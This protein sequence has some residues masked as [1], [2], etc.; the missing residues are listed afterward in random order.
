MVMLLMMIIMIIIRCLYSVRLSE[1]LPVHYISI[2]NYNMRH[3]KSLNLPISVLEQDT[4]HTPTPHLS[5]NVQTP[6]LQVPASTHHKDAEYIPLPGPDSEMGSTIATTPGGSS[7]AGTPH[8]GSGSTPRKSSGTPA[9]TPTSSSTMGLPFK[10]KLKREPLGENELSMLPGGVVSPSVPKKSITPMP[11]EDVVTKEDSAISNDATSK[12]VFVVTSHPSSSATKVAMVMPTPLPS[13]NNAIASAGIDMPNGEI[14][15]V[16]IPAAIST[17]AAVTMAT[18]SVSMATR[19]T[20]PLSGLVTSTP[21]AAVSM[22][23][24]VHQTNTGASSLT[25]QKLKAALQQSVLSN[26]MRVMSEAVDQVSIEVSPQPVKQSICS[27]S[28]MQTTS[29][30]RPQTLM[31]LSS[32]QLS[33][34]SVTTSTST[35]MSPDMEYELDTEDGEMPSMKKMRKGDDDPDERRKKFLERNRAAAARCR[36]KKKNWITNL[37]KKAE[38]LQSTN[39]KLQQEVTMLRSEVAQLKTLLLAHKD[40]PITLQLQNAGVMKAVT[41]AETQY[42]SISSTSHS[43]VAIDSSAKGDTSTLSN[44]IPIT[45][46][47]SGIIHTGTPIVIEIK[48]DM[49]AKH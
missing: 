30:V 46:A 13:N 24:T 33:P 12:P 47:T 31:K 19:S 20:T 16:Q 21:V 27:L 36:Q 37:E 32:Q 29:A 17:T 49:L 5:L 8:S 7:C 34:Q 43:P 6:D 41:T 14:K 39:N 22:A 25:K 44:C 10:L 2:L 23:T 1:A 35:P 45:L 9:G 42:S 15:P 18:A 48:P 38:D 26:N 3:N 4:L 40:C 11:K 28:S